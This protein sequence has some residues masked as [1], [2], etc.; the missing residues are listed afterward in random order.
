MILQAIPPIYRNINCFHSPV[1]DGGWENLLKH[2]AV[3]G[4]PC[5]LVNMYLHFYISILS[6]LWPVFMKILWYPQPEVNSLS[7]K[8]HLC[9]F[10]DTYHFLLCYDYSCI[11]IT[12]MLRSQVLW[13]KEFIF[14]HIR[15]LES[16][17]K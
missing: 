4:Y 3:C 14:L 2:V 5:L 10:H 6:Y 17:I 13:G 9:F 1:N 7:S 12:F 11:C 16:I 15:F 8:T